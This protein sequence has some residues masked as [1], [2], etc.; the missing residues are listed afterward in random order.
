MFAFI[1]PESI[2]KSL[3]I[4]INAGFSMYMQYDQNELYK[5]HIESGGKK[6]S[7]LLPT[8]ILVLITALLIWVAIYAKDI[9]DNSIVIHDDELYYTKNIEK[10]EVEK[11]GNYLAGVYLF[12]NDGTPINAGIDKNINGYIFSVCIKESFVDNSELNSYFRQ[13]GKDISSELLNNQYVQIN[14]CDKRFRVLKELKP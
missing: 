2:I 14:L 12:N 11:L 4:G 7:Y 3:F 13:L 8:I 5:K 6:A 9:P 1:G 10:A